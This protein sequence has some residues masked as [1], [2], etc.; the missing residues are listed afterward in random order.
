MGSHSYGITF[1]WDHIHMESHSYG[2]TF[3]WDHIHM[4]SHSYGITFIW[5]HIHMGSHSYGITFIW[6]HIHMGSHSYGIT[7][8]WDHIHM[9]SHSYGITFIWNHIHMGSHSYRRT[10]YCIWSVI[11]PI[12]KLSRLS[13]SQR[14]FCHAPLKRNRLDWDWKMRLNATPN[15]MNSTLNS[16]NVC[17][18][19]DSDFIRLFCKRAL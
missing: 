15:A 16:I 13:S 11:S 5:D 7:F 2:I 1:I 3:I 19:F 14:L 6:D 17:S 8:I 18:T 4:G 10:A 9:G 12:S